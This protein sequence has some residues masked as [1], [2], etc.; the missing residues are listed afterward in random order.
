[1]ELLDE[2]DED[3]TEDPDHAQRLTEIYAKFLIAFDKFKT[4]SG[5]H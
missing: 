1:L 5:L 4:N 3:E 2:D